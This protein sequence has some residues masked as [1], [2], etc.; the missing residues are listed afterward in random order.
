MLADGFDCRELFRITRLIDSA[1]GKEPPDARVIDRRQMPGD[2]QGMIRSGENLVR[3][4]FRR[5]EAR[6]HLF[7]NGPNGFQLPFD[8]LF[9]IH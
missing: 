2:P 7:V 4:F 3:P 1:F 5:F 6:E 8:T 9:E